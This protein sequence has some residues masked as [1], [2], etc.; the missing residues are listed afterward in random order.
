MVRNVLVLKDVYTHPKLREALWRVRGFQ[1]ERKAISRK[2]IL[3]FQVSQSLF[4]RH[5]VA[6]QGVV[7][8]AYDG[9]LEEALGHS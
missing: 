5:V 1:K 9:G 2:G 3:L 8:L 6:S 7:H 4:Q